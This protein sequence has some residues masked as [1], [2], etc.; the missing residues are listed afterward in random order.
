[1][2]KK[3]RSTLKPT[4]A[5]SSEPLDFEATLEEV[6]KVV[7]Q[8][9]SGQLGLSASLVEYEKGIEKIKRCHAAL[10]Q[11]ERRISVLMSVDEDGTPTVEPVPGEPVPSEPAIGE[12]EPGKTTTSNAAR[13]NTCGENDPP[14]SEVDD[15]TGLF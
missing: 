9:E 6:E 15:Q 5:E 13:D 4:D 7:T 1:M 14:A 11:A 12:P 2:A 10:E 8:L 3:K